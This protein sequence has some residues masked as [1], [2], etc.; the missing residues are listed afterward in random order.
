[1]SYPTKPVSPGWPVSLYVITQYHSDSTPSKHLKFKL[2]AKA[3][4]SPPPSGLAALGGAL[5][6]WDDL[7]ATVEEISASRRLSLDR[8]APDLG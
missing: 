1:M 7:D 6:E 5:A 2:P 4:F 8:P 3:E